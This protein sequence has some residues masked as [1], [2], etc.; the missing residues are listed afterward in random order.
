M[1]SKW[2]NEYRIKRRARDLIKTADSI[3]KK[4]SSNI[5]LE[6]TESVRE[7]L[8]QAQ[9]ALRNGSIKDLAV[10]V[11]ELEKT[12]EENLSKFRKSRLRQNVESIAIAIIL[13]LL[14]R[15][16]VVQP[17]KIPS[18]S[19]IPTLL[20]GDHLLVSKFIYGTK[21]PFTEKKIFPVGP[22]KRGDVVVFLY[23]NYERDPQ[24]EGLDYIKRVVGLP[25]DSIDIRGRTLYIN[26]EK[27]P[28]RYIGEYIDERSGNAFDKYEEELFGEKHEVIYKGGKNSTDRGRF[29]PVKSVPEGHLFVIGDNRD[30]SFD[31]RFWGFVPIQSIAGRAF[32]VHWSWN[33]NGDGPL[34]KVRWE[35]VCS[36]IY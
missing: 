32:M 12:V 13:A 26:G 15:T 21:I 18:G 22:I 6:R 25:G 29:L 27:I 9:N 23:P 8:I 28:L 2:L 4:Y 31:S 10:R 3:L 16:F 11:A 33:W 5:S 24:K 20:I 36:I 17:F 34:N 1:F 35:R 19:M 30:S 7:K 14:I